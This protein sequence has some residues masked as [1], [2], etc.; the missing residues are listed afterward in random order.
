[1]GMHS[2]LEVAKIRRR[3]IQKADSCKLDRRVQAHVFKTTEASH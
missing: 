1:M 3:G 2:Y